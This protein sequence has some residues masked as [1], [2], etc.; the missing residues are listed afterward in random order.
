MFITLFI[1]D[2]MADKFIEFIDPLIKHCECLGK[3]KLMGG[4]EGQIYVVC[5]SCNKG[6]YLGKVDFLTDDQ[7]FHY[8]AVVYAPSLG[9]R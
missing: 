3:F 6:Q 4:A 9:D 5:C 1:G 8:W 7:F 2:T